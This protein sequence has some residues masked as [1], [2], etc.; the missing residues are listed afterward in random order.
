MAPRRLLARPASGRATVW[1]LPV[2]LGECLLMGPHTAA[3]PV[4]LP[5]GPVAFRVR[6]SIGLLPHP[7]CLNRFVPKPSRI[8]A[9]EY[10]VLGAEVVAARS[11]LDSE[12]GEWLGLPWSGPAWLLW[13]IRPLILTPALLD[14][15]VAWRIEVLW[16][17]A[18]PPRPSE[19]E[20]PLPLPGPFEIH[21]A[22]KG[23]RCMLSVNHR[24]V[25]DV[26]AI[27]G[28]STVD[29]P[30]LFVQEVLKVV[31]VS[32][33]HN[34]KKRD[35]VWRRPA[36]VSKASGAKPTVAVPN[37]SS[38]SGIDLRLRRPLRTMEVLTLSLPRL[39][40]SPIDY[41]LPTTFGC[42]WALNQ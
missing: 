1:S 19:I 15:H 9:E 27:L 7:V 14:L 40:G 24:A 32:R 17:D 4:S 21:W 26:S 8:D 5:I 29:G 34:K 11:N 38:V 30:V 22:P 18:S 2:R 23:R 36:Y 3:V 33:P 28:L 12:P 20:R 37:L 25:P 42:L 6:S 10:V 13:S 31:F 16:G 35:E 39:P 41:V